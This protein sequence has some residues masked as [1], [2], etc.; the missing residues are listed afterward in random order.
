MS[1]LN[2]K[3][4]GFYLNQNKTKAKDTHPDFKGYL[5]ITPQ[6]LAGLIDIYERSREQHKD[7]ILQI[8]IAAWKRRKDDGEVF[9][10][11]SN[12][13]Y[14]GERKGGNS[15]GGGGYSNNGGGYS[16]RVR[17]TPASG[18]RGHQAPESDFESEEIPF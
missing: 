10:Y 6:Q 3:G 1:E 5:R 13:V 16:N 2:I 14:T 11:A 12:E 18:G 15:N 17:N 4:D 8:D 9:L 7:P